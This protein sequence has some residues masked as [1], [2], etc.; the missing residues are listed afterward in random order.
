[1]IYKKYKILFL[2]RKN[3]YY[4]NQ[5]INFFKKKNLYLHK[6]LLL[7]PK[8]EI[9][10]KKIIN[11]KFDFIFSFRSYIILNERV[12]NSVKYFSV[13]FHP[14]PPNYR[15]I[16]CVN[17]ALFDKKKFY[18]VTSHIMVKKV[19][20]GN[21]IHVIRFPIKKND[22]VDSLLKESYTQQIKQIKYVVSLILK[23]PQNIN[24]LLSNFKNEKWSKKIKNRNDLNKFYE[25]NK[26]ISKKNLLLKLKS[27]ENNLF[28]PY[29]KIHNKKFYYKNKNND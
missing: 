16:G 17:Y 26:N 10:Q 22:T 28:K 9:F 23:N 12:L 7:K 3:D 18:G 24:K 19:D 1:M 13:N 11:K 4:S 20:Y 27:T 6:I 5:V 2:G 25:I 8:E 15:G 29:I 14:G 21:I